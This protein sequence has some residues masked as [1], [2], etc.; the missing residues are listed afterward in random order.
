MTLYLI[1][2]VVVFL[3]I[4]VAIV[5]VIVRV[6]GGASRKRSEH[7]EWLADHLGL[8][9]AGGEPRYPKAKFL[10]FI[11]HPLRIEGER[12]GIGIQIYHYTVSSGQSST[13][14]TTVRTTIA[15]PRELTFRF[16]KENLFTKIG[17]SLGMQDIDTGDAHFDDLFRVKCN[18]EAFIR[19]ALLEQVK[20]RFLDAWEHHK[21]KGAIRLE[22][23]T[24]S[25][26]EI[27]I[28]HDEAT[29]SRAAAIT[30]LICD[31]GG[32]VQYYN[33]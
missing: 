14:Y 27:G 7:L 26:D 8:S 22:E 24:L 29:R 25:Y 30:E 32:I 20:D 17:K 28:I 5:L 11:R 9:L 3:V 10:E 6:A 18:D 4:N 23:E 19:Q 31:L 1:I 33:R 2:S 21:A 13:T 15:N 12:H 16:G